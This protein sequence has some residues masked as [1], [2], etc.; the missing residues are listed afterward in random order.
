MTI[1]NYDIVGSYNNQ[2]VLSL[3]AE[4]TINLFEYID[5]LAKKP[6]ALL[7][8]SGLDSSIIDFPNATNGFRTSFY[9]NGNTYH[10]I[11]NDVFLVK[12]IG[13]ALIPTLLNTGIFPNAGPLSTSSGYVGVDANTFQIIFVDSLHGYICDT[14]AETFIQITDT[15]FPIQPIDV[16]NLDGFFVVANGNTENFQ[17]STFDQGMVWGP[18]AN[19]FTTNSPTNNNFTIGAST[20]TGASGAANYATGVP[21]TVSNS[22]GALPTTTPQINN[23]T[24][25]FCIYINST[26]IQLATSYTNAIAGTAIVVNANGSGTQTITSQGQL[27]QGSITTHPGTIVACRTLH[28]K[29]FLFSQS[30]TEVW[31]NAG[32]GTNLPFRRN[33]SLLIEYGCPAIGSISVGFDKMIFLSQS[34]GGLGQVMQIVGTQSIPISTFALDYQ[35]AQYAKSQQISDCVGFMMK[36]S[37]LIFYRMNFTLANH[38]FVYNLSQSD[39]SQ[40]TTKFW[41]EEELLNYNRHPAQ[42]H[43]YY[44]GINYVGDYAVPRLY[45]ID[46]SISTNDGDDIR[47]VRIGRPYCPP[48]Y[49][50]IRVDR[51]QLD[52]LQGQTLDLIFENGILQTENGL[53]LLTEDG[54]ELLTEQT[55]P[56]NQTIDPVI[57]LSVSKDGAQTYGNRLRGPMGQSGERTFRTVWRKLGTTKRG[58][59]FVPMIEFFNPIPFVVLGAGWSFEVLPE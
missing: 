32:I 52:V 6:K 53:N 47:R 56:V 49:Q 22:G 14:T 43:V 58:Q 38:T 40:D 23:T 51:F 24:T 18:A 42:T 48:G 33:N 39:P 36:E 4:R 26:N 46:S 1:E 5:P 9:F 15:S 35:L 17:L 27:Q 28:R 2:R 44:N 7:P 57:F 13:N 25:Y 16:C 34:S 55:F 59:S 29:L 3:D 12:Q 11:G 10:V 31:E 30:F 20:I 45:Q 41:H 8:T 19:N 21:V 54:Y 37:G 50:R